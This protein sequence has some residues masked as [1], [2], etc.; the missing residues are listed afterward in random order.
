MM[1]KPISDS[2]DANLTVGVG[3]LVSLMFGDD[4][5]RSEEKVK[6]LRATQGMG[7]KGTPKLVRSLSL[8]AQRPKSA[9][10]KTPS[11]SQKP[12]WNEWHGKNKGWQ[13]ERTEATI[14]D[15]MHS[16]HRADSKCPPVYVHNQK[17]S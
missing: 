13:P 1:C 2:V 12:A 17:A 7:D 5:S 16:A 14:H 4:I 10:A 6:T 15:G 9:S 3:A 11:K 8:S